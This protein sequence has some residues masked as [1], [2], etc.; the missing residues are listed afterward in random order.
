[1]RYVVVTQYFWVVSCKRIDKLLEQV[2]VDLR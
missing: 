1:M 2:Y